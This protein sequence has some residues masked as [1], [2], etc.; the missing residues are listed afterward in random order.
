MLHNSNKT[1]KFEPSH[2]YSQAIHTFK[3][4]GLEITSSPTQIKNGTIQVFDPISNRKFAICASGYIRTYTTNYWGGTTTYQLNPTLK[5][6]HH[7]R[8]YPNVSRVVIPGAYTHMAN[9][10]IKSIQR[11]RKNQK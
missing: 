7:L 8:P 6:Q 10:L 9:L 1:Y 2:L 4:F 5:T 3:N 11:I